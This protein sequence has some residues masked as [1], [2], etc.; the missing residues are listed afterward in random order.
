MEPKTKKNT[1][2]DKTGNNT[3]NYDM[4]ARKRELA[5]QYRHIKGW[6]IDA[7][8][9]NEPTYPMKK[10]TGVDHQR[11]NYERPQQQPVDIEVLHSNERPSVSAVFGNTNPPSGLSGIIR[12]FAFRYSEESLKHWFALV[13]ADRINVVE[14]VIDDLKNRHVPNVFA[15]M[16]WGADM[17]Y[18]KKAMV[19]R[20]AVTVLVTT[21]LLI[22]FGRKKKL[23]RSGG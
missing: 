20:V 23:S 2:I 10:Y 1:G 21:A 3:D 6:G 12:R 19:K 22:Y 4:E 17:K 16:G 9:D 14:G 8:P 11:S 15:E 7:N 5:D 13:L 18:N